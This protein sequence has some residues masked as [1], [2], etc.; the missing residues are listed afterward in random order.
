MNSR[1]ALTFRQKPAHIQAALTAR[2]ANEVFPY[3]SASQVPACVLG[4]NHAP[5][6]NPSP[7][8]Q[9]GANVYLLPPFF[10]VGAAA[11]LEKRESNTCRKSQNLAHRSCSSLRLL[12][13]RLR[14]AK[15]S[16]QPQARQSAQ[17][18]VPSLVVPALIS[19]QAPS[20]VVQQAQSPRRT[21]YR[22][23]AT[24]GAPVTQRTA[25]SF[26]GGRFFVFDRPQHSLAHP[27]DT[28]CLT[29]S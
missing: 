5:F 20:S 2:L 6:R 12:R 21:N 23:A 18:R 11:F 15:S 19:L 27:K 22:S 13:A 9:S 1:N 17:Q 26:R 3:Q 14:R 8:R 29:R 4:P 24:R 7:W 28:E 25:R 16:P 10:A